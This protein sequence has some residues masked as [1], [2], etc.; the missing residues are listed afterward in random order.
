MSTTA[1]Q[2]ASQPVRVQRSELPLACPRPQDSLWNMHPRVYL[3]IE[4]T[5]EAAPTWP[6]SRPPPATAASIACF[7]TSSPRSRAGGSGSIC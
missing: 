5:G 6:C 4:K 2:P 3:P 1:A 7:A